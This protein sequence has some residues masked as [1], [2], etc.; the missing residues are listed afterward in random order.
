MHQPILLD[1]NIDKG[2]FVDIAEI[3]TGARGYG[4]RWPFCN[5]LQVNFHGVG[6]F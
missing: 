6:S 4:P 1:A 2:A 3:G 5:C